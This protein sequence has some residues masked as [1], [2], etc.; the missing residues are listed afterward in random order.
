MVKTLTLIAV[1]STGITLGAVL[2][3]NEDHEQDV[4]NLI[5]SVNYL[6]RSVDRL[7]DIIPAPIPVYCHSSDGNHTFPVFR[8][9]SSK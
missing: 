1:F 2:Q 6:Q 3:S 8:P 4:R 7:A 9:P 5:E